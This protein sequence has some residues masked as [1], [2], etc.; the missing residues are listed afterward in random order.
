MNDR[1]HGGLIS[2][3]S[4]GLQTRMLAWIMRR[5]FRRI[6]YGLQGRLITWLSSGLSCGR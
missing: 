2:W 4:S 5:L 6:I 3:F 1:L